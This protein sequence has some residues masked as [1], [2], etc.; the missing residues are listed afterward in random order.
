MEH[1]V[2]ESSTKMAISATK[3]NVLDEEA[4]VKWNLIGNGALVVDNGTFHF[5]SDESQK[6]FKIEIA[7]DTDLPYK[8][9][10][11]ETGDG[12]YLGET[13]VTYLA[14]VGKLSKHCDL[15]ELILLRSS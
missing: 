8:M 4:D 1:Y 3:L 6:V 10:L 12:F 7:N 14:S 15:E 9:E 2:T 5:N 11:Y 13:T